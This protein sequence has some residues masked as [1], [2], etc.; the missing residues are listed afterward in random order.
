MLLAIAALPFAAAS[1]ELTVT[2]LDGTPITASQIR[3]E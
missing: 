3:S 2:R 1:R